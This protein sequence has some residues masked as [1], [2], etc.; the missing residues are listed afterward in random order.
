MS[1]S[2]T[3]GN[4]R[5][6]LLNPRV[7]PAVGGALRVHRGARQGHCLEDKTESQVGHCQHTGGRVGKQKGEP[8]TTCPTPAWCLRNASW[9]S[10]EPLHQVWGVGC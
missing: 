1:Y 5:I 6:V 7:Q 8:L 10:L 9:R 3:P 4:S 2:C